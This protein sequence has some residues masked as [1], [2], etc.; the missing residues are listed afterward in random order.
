MII[1]IIVS[2]PSLYLLTSCQS[3]LLYFP[4]SYPADAVSQ[5]QSTHGE[6][7]QVLSYK[8]SQGQQRAFL[9]GNLNQ[10][11]CLW[12][13]CGGNATLALDWS[14]WLAEHAHP[15]DAW[16]IF[17]MPGYGECEGNP[18]PKRIRDSIKTVM[19]MAFQAVGWN[20]N[21]NPE[22]LRFFGHSLGSAV[23]LIAASEY[24]IQQGVLLAPFTSTMEMAEIMVGLPIGFLVT[25]R[26][27]NVQRLAELKERGKGAIIIFHGASDQ[28]IPIQMSYD[29]Q[30]KYPQIID[31]VTVVDAD[32]NA[33]HVSASNDISTALKSLGP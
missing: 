30:S 2:A 24:E 12:I 20:S 33:L 1:I 31:V 5:W 8:T 15:D 21:P 11:R 25:Q 13:A 18:N 26:Y 19:P 29:I 16:L 9:Q 10:P 3:K 23:V 17:D 6:S 14:N 22:K 4:R 7:A 32:H 27:D 28:I